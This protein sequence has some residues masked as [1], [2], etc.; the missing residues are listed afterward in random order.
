MISFLKKLY[1]YNFGW[2]VGEFTTIFFWYPD[3]DQRFLMRIRIRP[4]DTDPKH[5]LWQTTAIVDLNCYDWQLQLLTWIV[6]TDNCN[7]FYLNYYKLIQR[8][9]NDSNFYELI[10]YYKQLQLL[11][12]DQVLP[13]TAIV[14]TSSSITNNFNCYALI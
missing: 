14:M 12:P 10:Q 3:P 6:M 7:C 9:T 1:F 13:T 2:F 11:W 4:N 8:I 5:W